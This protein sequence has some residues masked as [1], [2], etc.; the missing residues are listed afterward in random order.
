MESRWP[1]D[2]TAPCGRQHESLQQSNKTSA[3]HQNPRSDGASCD[4]RA[5]CL[6]T[7]GQADAQ[8]C[9][10]SFGRARHRCEHLG[11]STPAF[12]RR[13]RLRPEPGRSDGWCGRRAACCGSTPK[14]MIH[15]RQQILGRHRAVLDLARLAVGRAD[16]AAAGDAAAGKNRRVGLRPV[17]ATA[18]VH[19]RGELRRAAMLADADDQRLV[20]QAAPL[21]VEDQPGIRTDRT[22]AEAA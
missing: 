1:R 4:E 10:G 5:H 14:Q 11:D 2:A 8:V 3:A 7:V 6:A 12:P 15:R 20:E 16:D 19:V 17:I 22:A 9:D 21:Q 13:L 18:P